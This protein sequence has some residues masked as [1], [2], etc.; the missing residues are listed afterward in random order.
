MLWP[1]AKH[2]IS[3]QT[4]HKHR[5]HSTLALRP[6]Q[7]ELKG[8]CG[9]HR[10][11]ACTEDV[12]RRFS[13]E[14]KG[15]AQKMH[16]DVH[17]N[18]SARVITSAGVFDLCQVL[19]LPF[20]SSSLPHRPRANVW[21]PIFCTSRCRKGDGNY[22]HKLLLGTVPRTVRTISSYVRLKMFSLYFWRGK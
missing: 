9:R 1:W 2:F 6:T 20:L 15:A 16:S 12:G 13:T 7:S 4:Q 14:P 10:L 3:T 19:S 11:M 21:R 17:T 18:P 8:G 5:L 22:I